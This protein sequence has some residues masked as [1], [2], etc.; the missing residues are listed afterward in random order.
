MQLKDPKTDEVA[1]TATTYYD[2]PLTGDNSADIT[3]DKVSDLQSWYNSN[4]GAH[5]STTAERSSSDNAITVKSS[6]DYL[7]GEHAIPGK[8]GDS[9]NEGFYYQSVLCFIEN[10]LKTIDLK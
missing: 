5:K 3:F 2:I 7:V 1:Y 9:S 8:V 10:D 4:A 6:Y